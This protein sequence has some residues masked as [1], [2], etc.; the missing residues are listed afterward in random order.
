[1]KVKPAGS[2]MT[3]VE[4]NM[5][6]V[7]VSYSTPVAYIDFSTGKAYRTDNVQMQTF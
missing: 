6:R 7:L 4:T 1:M 5:K 2:N 3:E